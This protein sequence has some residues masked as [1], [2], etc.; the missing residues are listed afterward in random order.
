MSRSEVIHGNGTKSEEMRARYAKFIGRKVLFISI[1]LILLILLMGFSATLGS[2]RLDFV[3]VYCSILHNFFPGSFDAGWLAKT[4]VWKIRLPRIIMAVVAGTGLASAGAV[5]QSILRNPL[6]SPYTLGISSAASFGASL[7]IVAGVGIVGGEYLIVI[8]AFLFAMLASL[9]IYGL[10]KRRNASPETMILAGIALMYLFSA[11][12]S[13]LQYFGESEAVKEV[14]FWMMGSLG[15]ASWRSTG[16]ISAVI[17]ICTPYLILK[18]WD[19]N[20]IGA[21]DETAKSLGVNVDRVRIICMFIASLMT[22]SILSTSQ[23]LCAAR[24]CY[25]RGMC[26]KWPSR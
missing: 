19:L 12:T 5:M 4:V 20:A 24:T 22:A 18:A 17:L 9:L 16:I 15:R 25:V 10:S 6:A 14:V 26:G 8:N 7:A 2:A 1:L 21:G 13:L 3:E 23:W 11:M